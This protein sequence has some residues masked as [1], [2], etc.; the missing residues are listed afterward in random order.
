MGLSDEPHINV[1]Y[2]LRT[3]SSGIHPPPLSIPLSAIK[4]LS[5]GV[6]ENLVLLH[7]RSL[8]QYTVWRNLPT[9]IG[10][11]QNWFVFSSQKQKN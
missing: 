9:R 2:K 4:A 11:K 5:S 1:L 7:M 6:S 3:G 8:N 10:H